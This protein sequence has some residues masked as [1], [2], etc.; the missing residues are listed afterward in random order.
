[1]GENLRTDKAVLLKEYKT[2]IVNEASVMLIMPRRFFPRSILN[3][4][5]AF[6]LINT[7]TFLVNTCKIKKKHSKL[8]KIEA[9]DFV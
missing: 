1:M 5:D 8:P 7:A 3:L 2:E 9:N 4:S 6:L